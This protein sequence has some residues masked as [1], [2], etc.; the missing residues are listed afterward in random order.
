MEYRV[1]RLSYDASLVG[2]LLHS[3]CIGK[4]G[5]HACT[6]KRIQMTSGTKKSERKKRRNE[7]EKS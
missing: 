6:N 1:C 5:S 7:Q 3:I 4:E 2:C